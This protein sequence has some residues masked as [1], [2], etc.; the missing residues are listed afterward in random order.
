MLGY[1]S[2][3]K[4]LQTSKSLQVRKP[5]SGF[6]KKSNSNSGIH[7]LNK[8]GVFNPAP[9][10]L[11]PKLKINSPSDRYEQEADSIANKV[12]RIPPTFTQ[13]KP[14][15]NEN[16]TEDT[17]Q[18]RPLAAQI[19]T[20]NLDGNAQRKCAK[21]EEE[22]KQVLQTKSNSS[23]TEAASNALTNQIQ[24]SNGS[25][26][27]MDTNT[28]S[29]MESRFGTDFSNVRIHT[30]NSAQNMNQE[31][32]A[33]AFTVGNNI[34]FN[35][36]EYNPDLDTGKK[37]LAHELTHTL[38][39]GNGMSNTLM[40]QVNEGTSSN[41]RLQMPSSSN[42]YNA[43]QNNTTSNTYELIAFGT[44]SAALTDTHEVI[45][46]QIAQDLNQN[47]LIMG[48][49]IS[50]W[51]YTDSRDSEENNRQLGQRRA[52][53]VLA[54]LSQLVTDAETRQQMRAMSMGE[55][56]ND[57]EGDVPEFRKVEITVTRRNLNFSL[58]PQGTDYSLSERPQP[59]F[60]TQL[61]ERFRVPIPSTPPTQGL[62]PWFLQ[63]ISPP[64]RPRPSLRGLSEILTD[65]L[66][67]P[68]AGG[69][70]PL[71]RRIAGVVGIDVNESDIRRSLD[72]ALI[73]AGE[74]GLKELLRMMI[75]SIA[76]QPTPQPADPFAP[77]SSNFSAPGQFIL[78]TPTFRFRGL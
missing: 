33:K 16:I 14:Y 77:P 42:P 37:L 67:Q 11:Q 64:N 72:Q 21:C 20:L 2:S 31:I 25:G 26:Q 40:R 5:I 12:M 63:S 62:P 50:I 39:Q 18:Q 58:L 3:S 10:S 32:N 29:F 54:R 78:T 8:Y 55:E 19:S 34:Y 68:I 35:Q 27:S 24:Q 71:A 65:G 57:R 23:T 41:F 56:L 36:G 53:A 28:K 47:P 7:H 70:A 43:S 4:I 60:D 74:E 17:I 44:N 73:S 52:D 76:G 69:T 9:L 13:P 6:D 22:E 30:N 61:P 51:G 46:Q 59:S 1:K 49:F 38:Q 75:F 48:G 45:L 66:R 15:K